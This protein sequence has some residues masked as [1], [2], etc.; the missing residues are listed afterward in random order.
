MKNT[1]DVVL[2]LALPA[3]GKSEVRKFL[4]A[5][6]PTTLNFAF[7]IGHTID[8]DDY[9]YVAFM[10]AIDNALA[11]MGKSRLFF[12]AD[13]KPL[14]D[15]RDWGTLIELLNDDFMDLGTNWKNSSE[16]KTR[17]MFQRIDY[18]AM[19]LPNMR[20]RLDI[21]SNRVLTQLESKLEGEA[22]KIS[23]DK[24]KECAKSLDGATVFI[25]CARGGPIRATM[26][27]TPPMGYRHSLS[28]LSRKVLQ[29]ASILYVKVDPEQSRAKN[30]ARK[31]PVGF[32]GDTGVFH[33]VPDEVM[34]N[35]YGCDDIKFM[36][37]AS[38]KLGTVKIQTPDGFFGHL[39]IAVLDNTSDLTTFAQKGQ[40]SDWPEDGKAKLS[41]A[42]QV[43]FRHLL[44]IRH[45][46]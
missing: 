32:T 3:S 35:D 6:D 1:L 29:K 45:C 25:E 43:A 15:P 22:Q 34:D 44:T 27:L 42:L 23:D 10:R 2:I 19:R 36:V 40:P 12:H 13:D 5:Q 37:G 14:I 9:P 17:W 20:Y 31:P 41:T 18:A 26:P 38:D 24:E 11:E 33:F 28:L 39:P 46:R 8:L 7:H 21:I 30:E 16:S 4:R